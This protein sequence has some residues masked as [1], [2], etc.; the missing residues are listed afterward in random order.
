VRLLRARDG[1][2][3]GSLRFRPAP[4]GH[5]RTYWDAHMAEWVAFYAA[6]LERCRR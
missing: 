3:Q 6:Q 2:T 4:G 1:E 5:D